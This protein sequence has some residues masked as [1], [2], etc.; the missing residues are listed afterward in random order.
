MSPQLAVSLCFGAGQLLPEPELHTWCD[1]KVEQ[2][3][4]RLFG[5]N[6]GCMVLA[7][8]VQFSSFPVPPSLD[9]AIPEGG[10]TGFGARIS[11]WLA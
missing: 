3:K 10:F 7:A 4:S 6:L 9:R 11:S 5:E 1:H 8:V 2:L